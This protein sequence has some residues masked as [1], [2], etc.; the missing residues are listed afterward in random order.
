MS[1]SKSNLP[2]RMGSLMNLAQLDNAHL[3]IN[4]RAIEACMT[5]QLLDKA[6]VCPALQH[7]GGA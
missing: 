5:Q 4:L 3:G 1:I 7:V 2:I 6:N